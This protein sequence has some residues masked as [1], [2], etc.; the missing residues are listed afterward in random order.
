MK[1]VG[2][3]E[4]L[5]NFFGFLYGSIEIFSVLGG[6]MKHFLFYKVI[7]KYFF[8]ILDVSIE[9]FNDLWFS[10]TFVVLKGSMEIIVF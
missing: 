6:S 4:V 8:Y 3:L 7:G 2:I 5:M 9:I 1:I 10:E